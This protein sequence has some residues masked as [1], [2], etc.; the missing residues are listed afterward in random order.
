M[1]V[2][3]TAPS[4]QGNCPRA[5]A[6]TNWTLEKEINSQD[7][8][9]SCQCGEGSGEVGIPLFGDLPAPVP[10]ARGAECSEMNPEGSGRDPGTQP[11]HSQS[12]SHW[13]ESHHSGSSL[14]TPAAAFGPVTETW[15]TD[16]NIREGP[17]HCS[18]SPVCHPC[19]QDTL[20]LLMLSRDLPEEK[21]PLGGRPTETQYKQSALALLRAAPIHAITHA[22]HHPARESL[23]LYSGP[24]PVG[25][26]LNRVPE[27][28]PG[29][30]RLITWVNSWGRVTIRQLCCPFQMRTGL[31]GRQEKG[32]RWMPQSHDC[33][34]LSFLLWRVGTGF[35]AL[36]FAQ[37]Q[38]GYTGPPK[39]E[40]LNDDSS[41]RKNR[42]E[43]NKHS[44]TQS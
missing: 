42:A 15:R 30:P 20:L 22:W 21:P 35:W 36:P 6:S 25:I 33:Q 39:I 34:S 29:A 40:Q 31:P 32:H 44:S 28:L 13:A 27:G 9:E 1:V 16:R 10:P 17:E 23:T 24:V 18:C 8:R 7:N 19:L 41:T 5:L 26:S 11:G 43:T 4:L 3:T 2:E 37:P 38:E 14:C 12:G